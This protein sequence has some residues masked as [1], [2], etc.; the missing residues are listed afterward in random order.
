[1]KE[2][3][4]GN[5]RERSLITVVVPVYNV[6]T[7]L[8]CCLSSIQEQS[9]QNL[10]ILLIDDG[11]T[12]DSPRICQE[13]CEQDPR[14]R[15]IR[16][17]NQGL[18]PAR[19]TGLDQAK[20]SYIC[21]VDADDYLHPDYVRILYENLT[22]CHADFSVCRFET[23]EGEVP[24]DLIGEAG[25]QKNEYKVLD[26]LGLLN[27][28]LKGDRDER[29]TTMAAWNKLVSVDWLKG[30][31]F[32]NKWHE[33]QFMI[34]EYIRRCR[35]AVFTTAVLYEYRKRPDS[36]TGRENDQDLRH[37]DDLE[38]H[39]QR[40]WYFYRPKYR[41][42]WGDLFR[43]DLRNK[44]SWYVCLYNDKNARSLKK[45]I[46][47]SYAWS[48]RQYLLTGRLFKVDR[49]NLHFLIFMLSPGLY[50]FFKKLFKILRN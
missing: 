35:K 32:V 3:V 18:G 30:F 43:E 37:L 24:E 41:A 1:M 19:N 5:R 44:I 4:V 22:G 21:F 7:Y 8:R 23:F 39:E 36:I 45:R 15:L 31:R 6:D 50:M 49:R 13:Y 26:Q 47:P 11:S 20:G 2:K 46:H 9:Y 25:K 48:F 29:I 12:D 16:Q 27:D 17:K 34:N 42:I 33:D 40:I 38:A 14:F 28:L 10:E